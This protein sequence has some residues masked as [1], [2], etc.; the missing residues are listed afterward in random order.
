MIHTMEPVFPRNEHADVAAPLLVARCSPSTRPRTRAFGR[1]SRTRCVKTLLRCARRRSSRPSRRSVARSARINRTGA[2]EGLSSVARGMSTARV[3]G[4]ARSGS[5]RE[6]W[7]RRKYFKARSSYGRSDRCRG[8]RRRHAAGVMVHR[9][10]G[11]RSL[12]RASARDDDSFQRM[13]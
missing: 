7:H 5:N 4:S 8:A 10:W 13:R 9:V 6:R 11:V 1:S 3:R 2:L 12:R